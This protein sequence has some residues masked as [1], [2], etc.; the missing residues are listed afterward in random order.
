AQ[1]AP[2]ARSLHAKLL[3]EK[4]SAG[5]SDGQERGIVWVADGSYVRPMAVQIGPSDG[6]NTEIVGGDLQPGMDVV[7]GE[8]RRPAGGGE[9]NP[10]V[11][12]M[13]RGKKQGGE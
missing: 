5:D 6:V 11:P 13:T 4:R 8:G 2:D 3:R 9:S 12:Q 10:F 1:I 7:I